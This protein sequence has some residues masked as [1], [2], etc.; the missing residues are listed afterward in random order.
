M[1]SASEMLQAD[2]RL[3][4]S[5]LRR[6]AQETHQVADECEAEGHLVAAAK[7][8]A[9]ADRALRDADRLGVSDDGPTGSEA[10]TAVERK[11]G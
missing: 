10:V 5:Y 4:G 1:S 2:P 6:F 11:R 8:R 7:L 3:L 9:R